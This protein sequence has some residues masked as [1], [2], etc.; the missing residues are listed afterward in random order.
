M[1]GEHDVELKKDELRHLVGERHR[2]VIEASDAIQ[3]M[4]LLADKVSESVITLRDRCLPLDNS[5]PSTST[6]VN[7]SIVY[8]PNRKNSSDENAKLDPSVAAHLKL[9]LDIPEMIWNFMDNADHTAAVTLLFFGRHISARLQLSSQAYNAGVD[10]RV[11]VKRSWNSLLHMESAVL[12][13]CR[14]RLNAPPSGWEELCNSLIAIILLEN[15][16]LIKALDELMDGRMVAL[17]RIFS[18]KELPTSHEGIHTGHSI[19]PTRRQAVLSSRLLIDALNAP[20]YLF[21]Q[22]PDD[23][24]PSM[25]GAIQRELEKLKNWNLQG[26]DFHFFPYKTIHQILICP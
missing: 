8:S 7:V 2:D 21:Y 9:L 22:C 3:E 1:D 11:L 10:A 15:L 4:K 5:H 19:L 18:G 16:S 12:A 17:R 6:Y 14:R 13:A 24:S 23:H 20:V 26:T 25:K